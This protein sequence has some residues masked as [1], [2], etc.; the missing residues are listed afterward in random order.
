MNE[1]RQ[2][3]Y[4]AARQYIQNYGSPFVKTATPV[5]AAAALAAK[6]S[7][8]RALL[9]FLVSG[10][11]T[12]GIFMGMGHLF[13]NFPYIKSWFLR[14][15]EG[16]RTAEEDAVYRGLVDKYSPLYAH[17]QA[18]RTVAAKYG[19]AEYTH[20]AVP[21]KNLS[22]DERERLYER[23]RQKILALKKLTDE[24]EQQKDFAVGPWGPDWDQWGKIRS[25]LLAFNP[26]PESPAETDFA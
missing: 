23:Q 17:E 15:D 3:A 25:N 24:Q 13:H 6:P 5:A 21:L 4:E 10:A 14:R 19:L 8:L 7:L 2:I 1:L 26:Q 18:I 11:S 20:D 12:A 9:Q 22:A 16:P